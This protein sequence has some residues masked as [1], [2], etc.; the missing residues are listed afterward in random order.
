MARHAPEP[1]PWV[2]PAGQF[3]RD[4]L[5]AM[6]AGIAAAGTHPLVFYEDVPYVLGVSM[7]SVRRHMTGVSRRAGRELHAL[8]FGAFDRDAWLSGVHCYR[9]QFIEDELADFSARLVA[10]SGERLW[11]DA[12]ALSVM[13][14]LFV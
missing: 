2:L 6:V 5:L 9:S 11:A 14:A 7:E 12:Q 10:R 3:H 4:H 8:R 1:G 13:G